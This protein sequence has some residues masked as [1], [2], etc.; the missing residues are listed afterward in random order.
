[1]LNISKHTSNLSPIN[2]VKH[3]SVH[4]FWRIVIP[5]RRPLPRTCR[6]TVSLASSRARA[7]VHQSWKATHGLK[8]ETVPGGAVGHVWLVLWNI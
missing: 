5:F 2:N 3:Q 6:R 7:S 4:V 8:A 1:M